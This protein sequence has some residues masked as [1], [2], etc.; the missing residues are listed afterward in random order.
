MSAK[1]TNMNKNDCILP[2]SIPS[3]SL[4]GMYPPSARKKTKQIHMWDDWEA[5]YE[6]SCLKTGTM[7]NYLLI[8]YLNA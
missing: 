4:W 8:V 5:N 7:T 3:Y 2:V 6:L 1:I